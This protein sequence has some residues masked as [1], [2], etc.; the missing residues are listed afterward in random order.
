LL[1]ELRP[2]VVADTGQ[3]RFMDTLGHTLD[4][5]DEFSPP[6]YC[7]PRPTFRNQQPASAAFGGSEGFE[8]L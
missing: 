5:I 7:H 2:V 6:R 3:I 1:S 4:V 8:R